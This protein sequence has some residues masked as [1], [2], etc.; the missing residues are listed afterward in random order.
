MLLLALLLASPMD[1]ATLNKMAA[2]FAPTAISAD[3]AR[4]PESERGALEKIVAV[5]RVMDA[6]YLRQLRAGNETL[7]LQLAKDGTPLGK[8]RLRMF[9]INKGP[10]SNVD[11]DAA[12]IPGVPEKP[13]AA[14]FYPP[15]ATKDEVE[16]WQKSLQG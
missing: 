9:L 16:K 6:I 1:E 10:W 4:L 11:R 12:F 15:G 2:R 8:A 14:N 3:T 7:L 5:A 13:A